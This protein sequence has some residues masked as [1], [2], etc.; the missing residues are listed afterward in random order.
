MNPADPVKRQIDRA[1]LAGSIGD[2]TYVRVLFNMGYRPEEA[3]F[4]LHELR[5]QVRVGEPA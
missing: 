5:K 3:T 1:W 4:E 2:M